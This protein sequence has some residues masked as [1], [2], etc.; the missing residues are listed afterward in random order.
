[1]DSTK[2]SW[3]SLLRLVL[4]AGVIV[5]MAALMSVTWLRWYPSVDPE[6]HEEEAR[7]FTGFLHTRFGEDV[8]G[9]LLSCPTLLLCVG[10]A[11]ALVVPWSLGL[12]TLAHRDARPTDAQSILRELARDLTHLS[13]A[14]ALTQLIALASLALSSDSVFDVDT[15]TWSASL[16]L[17]TLLL[18][19]PYVALLTGVRALFG[20]RAWLAL[21]AYTLAVATWTAFDQ[22]LSMVSP[23]GERWLPTKLFSQVMVLST[24]QVALGALSCCV[25]GAACF[26]IT[27]VSLR[28]AQT[29]RSYRQKAFLHANHV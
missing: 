12:L 17:R 9:W 1:M 5:P 6:R 10:V 4:A 18:S 8:A 3:F 20:A 11:V 13:L 25:W 26:L 16:L 21:P 7:R 2:K 24:K 15:I 23:G 19:L 29:S 22:T 28:L 27:I 14:L